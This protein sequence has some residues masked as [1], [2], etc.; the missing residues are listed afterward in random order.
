MK[1]LEGQLRR[2]EGEKEDLKSELKRAQQGQGSGDAGYG[3]AYGAGGSIG[4]SGGGDGN[5]RSKV[6][7]LEGEVEGLRKD[8][9]RLMGEV[10]N[11]SLSSSLLHPL[12]F[13]RPLPRL[14]FLLA[15]ERGWTSWNH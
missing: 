8:N 14:L 7:E 3:G 6:I 1:D 4:R 11:V 5:M 2:A 15:L 9:V 12:P 13:P 10:R